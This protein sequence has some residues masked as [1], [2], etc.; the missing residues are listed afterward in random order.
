MNTNR[1]N[2]SKFCIILYREDEQGFKGLFPS[3]ACNRSVSYAEDQKYGVH[4]VIR[5]STSNIERSRKRI[6]SMLNEYRTLAKPTTLLIDR[7]DD[8]TFAFDDTEIHEIVSYMVAEILAK[9]MIVHIRKGDTIINYKSDRFTWSKILYQ[10]HLY[11]VASD[12]IR[13]KMTGSLFDKILELTNLN[14]TVLS[15]NSAILFEQFPQL[16][17]SGT[18]WRIKSAVYGGT[19]FVTA[20]AL[21]SY[22]DLKVYTYY[23]KNYGK[24]SIL[25]SIHDI[26]TSKG[27]IDNITGRDNELSE[28]GFL[29]QAKKL[30][31][32][33]DE[34]KNLDIDSKM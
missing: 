31:E 25:L 32:F 12:E 21:L 30:M 28:N 16:L 33:K 23:A 11:L 5:V 6:Y 29:K 24:P 26:E 7:M 20:F 34:P 22:P 4:G 2:Y 15:L 8:I 9:N 18:K 14:N 27:M 10:K 1:T 13:K 19:P 17:S 3:R